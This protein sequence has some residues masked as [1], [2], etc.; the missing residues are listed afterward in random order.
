MTV[1]GGT[2]AIQQKSLLTGNGRS[3]V[4]SSGWARLCCVNELSPTSQCLKIKKGL[5]VL[6]YNG[7]SPVFL[8]RHSRSPAVAGVSLCDFSLL[9]PGKDPHH[10]SLP[11]SHW[12]DLV[13]WFPLTIRH[14]ERVSIHMPRKEREVSVDTSNNWQTRLPESS[15]IRWSTGEPGSQNSKGNEI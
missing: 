15:H 12:P 11:T 6:I 7:R 8:H 10:I 13:T 9:Q 3:H 14:L 4:Y 1:S 2:I 5:T